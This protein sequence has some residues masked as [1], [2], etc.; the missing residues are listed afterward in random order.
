MSLRLLALWPLLLCWLGWAS[1]AVAARLALV[2]G[3][4]APL[5]QRA[6]AESLA[7]WSI[8]VVDW[9]SGRPSDDTGPLLVLAEEIAR[10]ANARWVVWREQGQLHVLDAELEQRE[11]R[12]IDGWPADEAAA[13]AMAL[14]IKTLLRLP[15]PGASRASWQ[16]VPLMQLG[17]RVAFD[18]DGGSGVRA[19]PGFE[20]APPPLRGVRVGVRAELGPELDVTGPSYKGTWFEWSAHASVSRDFA[21]R[22]WTVG[23]SLTGGVT[24][25][26]LDGEEMRTPRTERRTGASASI[27]AALGRWLGPLEVA[28]TTGV[29]VRSAG[30]YQR[31]QG[32]G[33]TLWQEPAVM[34][35]LM[36]LVALRL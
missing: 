26:T 36:A 20:V 25:S 22:E 15:R 7:P 23:V 8:E 1:P 19:T 9:P 10:N 16:F 35:S 27:N 33:G 14:T 12:P 21:L 17:Y 28:L 24:R 34:G 18:G 5:L 29:T 11:A 4:D 2:D 6:V 3:A 30:Q 13:T 31:Q 32:G